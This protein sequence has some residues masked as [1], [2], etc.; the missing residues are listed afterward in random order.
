[1]YSSSLWQGELNSMSDCADSAKVAV[2]HVHKVWQHVEEFLFK[3]FLIFIKLY[4]FCPIRLESVCVC[5]FYI[6]VSRHLRILVDF[7]PVYQINGFDGFAVVDIR[8]CRSCLV[9]GTP[10][11]GIFQGARKMEVHDVFRRWRRNRDI[12]LIRYGDHSSREGS[13]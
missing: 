6:L 2:P 10:F 11:L 1:M 13:C 8:F 3:S 9:P 4:F 12:N 5:A 7:R